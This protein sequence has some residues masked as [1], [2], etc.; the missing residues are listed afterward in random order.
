MTRVYHIAYL[1][2][3]PIQYQA[4][5]LRY[6]AKQPEIDLTVF[7]LSDYSIRQYHDEGFG[8]RLHWD[9]PLLDRYKHVFLPVAGR[10][11]QVSFWRPFV[12]GLGQHLREGSYDAL[13][14][15][16]Y[17]HQANLR[18]IA[19]ARRLGVKILLRGESHL[20]GDERSSAKEWLKDK[21]LPRL[22]RF[23]DGFLAIGSWNRDY[24]LHYDA[25]EKKIFPMPYAVDN[26]FFRT[27]ADQA[28]PKREL[29]KAELGLKPERP[30]ILYASKLH[31]R[32][33][34]G[35]LLEAYIRLS[36]DGIKE[37]YPYLLFVGDGETR[38]ALEARV[39]SLRWSSVK[40]LGFVNQTELPRFYDLCDLFVLPSEDEPWGLV[41][42]EVMNAG[43]AV[44]VSDQVGAGPD[45]V[46]EGEN[47]FVVPVSNLAVLADRL[48]ALTNNAEQCRVMGEESRKIVDRWNFHANYRGL[49]DA[50]TAIVGGKL[51]RPI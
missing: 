32:K 23:I 22:F 34:A 35:D 50:L 25:P 20:H 47:G 41:V 42:N 37:P 13:W 49:M 29:L 26:Q 36:E 24:Y 9:V 46:K 1:V 19:I 44:V 16:G 45:L 51:E 27:R 21:A 15:H 39:R 10:R 40:F 8:T 31:R 33:R 5:L 28:R 11:D 30:V 38:P 4:P 48:R 18:A 6:L 7:F 12:H 43:K 2:S 17:A 3:H 14:L